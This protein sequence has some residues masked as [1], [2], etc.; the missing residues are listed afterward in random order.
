MLSPFRSSGVRLRLTALYA[1]VPKRGPVVRNLLH[2][3]TQDLTFQSAPGA[4]LAEVEIVAVATS[5]G[6]RPVAT[7]A[8]S[9]KI[10]AP[11]DRFQEAL[12]EGALYTLDVPVKKR[13]AYQIQVAVRDAATGKVGSASQF[14][15]IPELKRG[16]VALTSIV[17]QTGNR[18]AGTPAWA[19]MAPVTRQ[20]RAGSQVE[21]FCFLEN[22][23]K[24][25]A[26]NLDSQ[27]RIVRGGQSVYTGPAKLVPIDGGGL[28]VTGTLKLG[29][30]MTPGDYYLGV[31]AADRTAPKNGVAAQWTDFEIMP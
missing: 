7:V 6:D 31:I 3:D 20:F 18:P 23:G 14:L 12:K 26:A 4:S 28:A 13:G 2:I 9:Y 27:I 17:L 5:M 29:E 25:L 21:Y 8:R 10:Q 24:V 19:G 15:E 11:A 16:R 1:E 30:R 22:A